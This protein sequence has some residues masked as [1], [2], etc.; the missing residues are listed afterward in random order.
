MPH[1]SAIEGVKIALFVLVIF[2]TLRL[3]ALSY[4]DNALS[5][6]FLLLF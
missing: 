1:V 2:G 5:Q 4:P 6:G 3:A